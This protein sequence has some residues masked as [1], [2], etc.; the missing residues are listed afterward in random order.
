MSCILNLFHP[1]SLTMYVVPIIDTVSGVEPDLKSGS[2][3]DV[4]DQE[5]D[6]FETIVRR[7]DGNK[8]L[9]HFWGFAN[10]WDT[11]IEYDPS[12]IAPIHTHSEPPKYKD[13]EKLLGECVW[14]ILS[15]RNMLSE[16]KK[17]TAE[18]LATLENETG[19]S[20]KALTSFLETA[21]APDSVVE[22]TFFAVVH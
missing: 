10:I 20:R 14:E 3:I 16:K 19:I 13:H 18:S 8:I 22:F 4:Q 2:K 6:W 7:V 15:H 21:D 11:L 12:K 1:P 5:G 17:C 9:C